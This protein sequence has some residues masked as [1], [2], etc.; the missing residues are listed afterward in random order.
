MSPKRHF[1]SV[2]LDDDES[3]GAKVSGQTRQGLARLG[4][5]PARLAT[6]RD[7]FRDRQGLLRAAPGRKSGL[8]GCRIN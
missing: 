8:Q 5:S 7:N 2:Y 4:D 1:I 6:D 3:L